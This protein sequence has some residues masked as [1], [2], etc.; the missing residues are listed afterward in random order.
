MGILPDWDLWQREEV[1]EI[2][3]RVSAGAEFHLAGAS[4]LDQTKV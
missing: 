2:L 4:D 3:R 1:E